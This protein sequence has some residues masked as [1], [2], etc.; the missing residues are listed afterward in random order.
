MKFACILKRLL[1]IRTD[2]ESHQK[3]FKRL[4]VWFSSVWL[5]LNLGVYVVPA[6]VSGKMVSAGGGTLKE[7]Q[8]I[9]VNMIRQ[10]HEKR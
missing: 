1:N 4:R 2:C 9:N 8:F 10:H 6:V 7:I 3:E 5:H